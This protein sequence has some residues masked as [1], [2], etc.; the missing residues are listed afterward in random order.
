MANNQVLGTAIIRIDGKS[1]RSKPGAG[2]ELG[3]FERTEV[4]ADGVMIGYSQKPLPAKIT[5][6]LAHV[7]SAQYGK[8]RDMTDVSLVFE[9]D[10]GARYTVQSAFLVRPPKITG[11]SGEVEVEFMGQ[12]ATER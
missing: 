3:G 7:S 4:L 6:T 10:N 9:C 11:D 2:I 1:I 5:A 8:M 12:P